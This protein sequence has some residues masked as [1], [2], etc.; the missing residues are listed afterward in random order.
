MPYKDITKKLLAELPV[1]SRDVLIKR[2]GL[3]KVS[4]RETLE[5]I[6]GEYKITRERVRQIEAFA[7]NLIKKSEAYT[8]AE[9]S[10]A[11]LKQSMDDFGGVVHEQ[12]FLESLAKDKSTQNHIHFIL[13]VAEAFTKLKED[14]NFHYRWTTNSE[15]ATKVHQS[16]KNLCSNF[17]E[18]DLISE[19]ELVNKFLVELKNIKDVSDDPQVDQFADKWLLLSKNLAKNPLGEWGLAVSPNIR[20][21]GIRDYAYLVL[22]QNKEPLHF[23]D[24]A[25]K[26]NQTFDRSAHPA[27]CHNELI[28][29]ARFV[30]VG[31]GLYALTEWGYSKGTVIEVIQRLL[32]EKGPLTRE[33]VI[34]KVLKKRQ[35]KNN[36]ILVN[37]QNPKFFKKNSDGKFVLAK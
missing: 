17:S 12:V 28:K 32:K 34:E 31:R 29:D 22:R 37:L 10:F 18:G 4:K 6:G 20:M 9:P 8:N 26:I 11:Q 30:L 5:A 19:P 3:G 2:Y 15:L 13:V 14:E 35:V 21:R 1:R 7:L 25:K 24:V 36:T 23:A 16:L 27:T 33:E